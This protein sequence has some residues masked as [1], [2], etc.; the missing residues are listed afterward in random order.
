MT[1]SRT[2]QALT[3][4]QPWAH[5]I[6]PNPGPLPAGYE[7]KR[8]ENR[9]WDTSYRKWDTSYRGPLAIHAGQS[10]KFM[11]PDDQRRFANCCAYGAVLGIAELVGCVKLRMGLVERYRWLYDDPYTEGPF[12]WILEN[13]QPLKQPHPAKGQLGLWTVE[14]PVALLE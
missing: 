10:R 6:C 8:V 7:P 2:F 9:K 1:H 14:I 13:V 4:C 11:R 5:L 12:C 3:I